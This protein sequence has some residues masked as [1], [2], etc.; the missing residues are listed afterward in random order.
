MFY[1][2]GVARLRAVSRR[3]GP[4]PHM[5]WVLLL[6]RSADDLMGA[7]DR[8]HVFAQSRFLQKTK[9]ASYFAVSL[10]KCGFD[11]G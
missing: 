6:P 7:A 1:K 5:G 10:S 9:R 4:R 8:A 11:L 3:E 2:Q